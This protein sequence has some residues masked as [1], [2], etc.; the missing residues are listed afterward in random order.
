MV[1]KI[2]CGRGYRERFSVWLMEVGRLDF[3]EDGVV[4]FGDEGHG[5]PPLLGDGF[6][7]V[8]DDEESDDCGEEGD[9]HRWPP[10]LYVADVFDDGCCGCDSA[11]D[12]EYWDHGESPLL[13]VVVLSESFPDIQLFAKPVPKGKCIF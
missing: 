1:K 8:G 6:G 9:C 11:E 3:A 12:G 5:E 2:F 4:V 13:R 7:F 10:F